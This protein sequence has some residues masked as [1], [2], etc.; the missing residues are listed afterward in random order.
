[1]TGGRAVVKG[2]TGRKRAVAKP[3]DAA[4]PLDYEGLVAARA[5]RSRRWTG[6]RNW[7]RFC[8]GRGGDWKGEGLRPLTVV[9][10]QE[11]NCPQ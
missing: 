7:K 6:K 3:P 11:N 1:M 10:S 9:R 5:C 8:S 4:L 2:K